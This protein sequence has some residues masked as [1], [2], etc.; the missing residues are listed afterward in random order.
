MPES[1]KRG[2]G[3]G[4]DKEFWT[5]LI[6]VTEKEYFFDVLKENELRVLIINY[7]NIR[8]YAQDTFKVDEDEYEYLELSGVWDLPEE[9][10][11]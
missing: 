1:A 10:L 3:K 5:D 7:Y 4:S 9:I 8:V 2:P 6:Y 11:D